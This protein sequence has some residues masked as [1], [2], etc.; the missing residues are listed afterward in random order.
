[1][2]LKIQI[3][4]NNN[5]YS[6]ELDTDMLK[7]LSE[8]IDSGDIKIVSMKAEGDCEQNPELFCT[9]CRESVA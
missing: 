6:D 5:F 9:P 8:A 2:S 4:N 7:R 3:S 1:M